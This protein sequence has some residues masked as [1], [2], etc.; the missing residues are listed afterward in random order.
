V[1]V[2]LVLER[3]ELAARVVDLEVPLRSIAPVVEILPLRV[4]EPEPASVRL[5][6]AVEAPMVPRLMAPE[7]LEMERA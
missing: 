6:R 7:P 2:L 5:V 3:V 1:A 4:L